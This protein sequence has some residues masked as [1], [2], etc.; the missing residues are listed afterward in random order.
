M[1]VIKTKKMYK[2]GS[3]QLN[4]GVWTCSDG[5]PGRMGDEGGGEEREGVREWSK[6]GKGSGDV[7]SKTRMVTLKL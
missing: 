5:E 6:K 7:G 1:Q 4:M 3:W 2:I